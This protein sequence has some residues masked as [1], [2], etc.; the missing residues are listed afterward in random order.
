MATKIFAS[1][2]ISKGNVYLHNPELFMR[3]LE[4]LEGKE[5]EI[6]IQPLSTKRS[7][8][9]NRYFWGVVMPCIKSFH[10]ETTGNKITDDSL[11]TY[12]LT[13]FA[14]VKLGVENVFGR[15]IIVMEGLTSSKMNNEQFLDFLDKIRLHYL[16]IGLDIPLPTDT[17]TIQSFLK[18]PS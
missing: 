9:L 11:Y 17:N 13:E 5:L 6:H 8:N 3:R 12:L 1:G 7:D 16:E 10:M 18:R 14:G 15:E 2:F 4:S